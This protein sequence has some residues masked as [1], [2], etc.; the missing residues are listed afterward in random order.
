MTLKH[1]EMY[2]MD[3]DAEGVRVAWFPSHVLKAIIV[4]RTKLKDAKQLPDA[5]NPGVYFLLGDNVDGK[6]TKVYAGQTTQGV[7]RLNDHAIRKDFWNRAVL[8]LSDSHTFNKDIISGLELLAIEAVKKCEKIGL[9]ESE[10]EK[11]PQYQIDIYHQDDIDS[12]FS[13]IKFVM[14]WLGC[15]LD[16]QDR[17]HK[18]KI[19]HTTRN[20]I[21]AYG[22]YAGERFEVLQGSM[23]KVD[24]QPTLRSYQDLRKE[25]LSAGTISKDKD[26]T[27]RMTE[28]RMFSTPSG[29]SDFVL[30]GSTNGWTEWKDESGKTLDELFRSDVK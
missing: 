24:R 19:F 1:M 25:M 8:F 4:P 22:V 27:Y 3:N 14:N 18:Q 28:N 13:D 9:Y 2:F 16:G 6:R 12:Y 20:K 5:S 11:L 15:G 7:D 23:I 29:A 17:S 10:N 26:G 21:I 30:G